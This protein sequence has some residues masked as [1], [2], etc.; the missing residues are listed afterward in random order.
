MIEQK[1]H[2]LG[3]R[4]FGNAAAGLGG[5]ERG[6]RPGGQV[7]ESNVGAGHGMRGRPALSGARETVGAVAGP[8]DHP[9]PGSSAG[10][11]AHHSAVDEAPLGL[12]Q[13]RLSAPVVHRVPSGDPA[14]VEADGAAA[15]LGGTA[16]GPGRQILQPGQARRCRSR[17]K[18]CSA[19]GRLHSAGGTAWVLTRDTACSRWSAADSASAFWLRQGGLM[20]D[21]T[22]APRQ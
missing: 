9:A 21:S 4:R 10:R 19:W 13:Q 16:R 12:R 14:Q 11:T 20:R 22:W 17:R 8:G 2:G 6:F 1:G 18:A 7:R 5:G 3:R 15:G